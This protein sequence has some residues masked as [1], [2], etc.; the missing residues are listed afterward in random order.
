MSSE[1]LRAKPN[2]VLED[3][4]IRIH[5]KKESGRIRLGQGLT[6]NTLDIIHD[7]IHVDSRA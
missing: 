2:K 3:V 6:N 7:Q 1:L 5:G 4:A